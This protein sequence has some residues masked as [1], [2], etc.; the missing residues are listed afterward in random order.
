MNAEEAATTFA[1]GGTLKVSVDGEAY[2]ILADEVEVK[3]LAKEGFAVAEDGP[4]VAALV[5]DLTPELIREGMAR[6]FVR[7][8]QDFRKTAAFNVADR[9]LLYLTA[10]PELKEAIEA[11]RE[12]IM[13]ETLCVE[14]HFA[15]SL[16]TSKM[17][18]EEFDGERVTI[19]MVKAGAML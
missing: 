2:E 5:T 9:I 6:E 1:K 12:T 17:Q 14:L 7:R 8:V 15:H 10:T 4:Y 11:H 19:A 18:V 13:T 3:T 16:V